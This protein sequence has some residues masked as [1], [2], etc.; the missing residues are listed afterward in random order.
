M[1]KI[2]TYS[3]ASTLILGS[4]TPIAA[5]SKE[6]EETIVANESEQQEFT[7]IYKDIEFTGNVQMSEE[8]LEGLYNNAVSPEPTFT[9]FGADSGLGYVSVISP[10]Y[11]T[12][13]NTTTKW[14]AELIVAYLVSKAPTKI[15]SAVF[16]SWTLGKIQGWASSIGPT[17]VGAWVSTSYVSGQRRYYET[18]AHYKNSNYTS[19]KSVQYYDVTA[20]W[21]K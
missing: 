1:K 21:K 2:I 3:L 18:L 13:K 7:Y 6:Q 16:G 11:V 17:Y 20:K 12:Y 8:Q 19:P 15:A 9:T 5:Q 4:A 14:A 10:K